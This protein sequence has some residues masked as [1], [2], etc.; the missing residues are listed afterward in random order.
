MEMGDDTGAGE[1]LWEGLGAKDEESM[2][3]EN[4]DEGKGKNVGE[5]LVSAY[6]LNVIIC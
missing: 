5:N 6:Y 3:K 1:E 4:T 2:D